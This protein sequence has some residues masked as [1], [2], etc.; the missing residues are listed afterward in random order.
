MYFYNLAQSVN[1]DLNSVPGGGYQGFYGGQVAGFIHDFCV[2]VPDKDT[3][4]AYVCKI[5]RSITIDAASTPFYVRRMRNVVTGQF[6]PV[7]ITVFITGNLYLENTADYFSEQ[8]NYAATAVDVG[9]FLAFIVGGGGQGLIRVK[10]NLGLVMPNPNL[11]QAVNQTLVNQCWEGQ[12]ALLNPVYC[13]T[14]GGAF[15]G[16]TGDINTTITGGN[17]YGTAA[18]Q[19]AAGVTEGIF[20]ADGD[21][22]VFSN[23]RS[24]DFDDTDCS[25]EDMLRTD[26]RYIH[27]GSMIAWGQAYLECDFANRE[28]L[29]QDN[30]FG[31]YNNRVPTETFI[32]RPDLVKNLPDW[33]RV[34]QVFDQEV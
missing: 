17:L 26:R 20:I 13:D 18:Q 27:Q 31:I 8:A 21:L 5:N 15:S 33:M 32:Y 28:H 6:E 11:S 24:E 34:V 3:S 1:R 10:D 19:S 30:T 7:K 23:R 25:E 29:C 16:C 2:N 4:H 9:N 12:T 22:E 14:A